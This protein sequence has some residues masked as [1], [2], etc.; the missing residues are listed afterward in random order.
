MTM[1]RTG[2]VSLPSILSASRLSGSGPTGSSPT[3]TRTCCMRMSEAWMRMAPAANHDARRWRGLAG[4]GEV[5]PADHHVRGEA[6]GAG[7]LEHADAWSRGIGSAGLERARTT[8]IEV[9]HLV[10]SATAP[11]L[12]AG[13]KSGGSGN[14]RESLD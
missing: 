2:L 9:G 5:V 13:A 14:H 12:G 11:C 1:L 10:D 8:R 3:R 6:N 7:D 4:D